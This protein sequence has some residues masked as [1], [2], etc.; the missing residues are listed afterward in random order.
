MCMCV[1]VRARVHAC[2]RACVRARMRACMHAGVFVRA[3][4]NSPSKMGVHCRYAEA[5]TLAVATVTQ[6]SVFENFCSYSLNPTSK[7]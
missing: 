2:V 1:C 3:C 6:A 5:L 4:Q 7:P